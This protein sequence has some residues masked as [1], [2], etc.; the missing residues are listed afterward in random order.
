MNSYKKEVLT[1]AVL[2][3]MA[4]AGIYIANAGPIEKETLIIYSD[5]SQAGQ[6]P[7]HRPKT[8]RKECTDSGINCRA[9]QIYDACVDGSAYCD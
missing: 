1:I 6:Y 5:D 2:F 7:C 3:V 9:W 8:I 4:I